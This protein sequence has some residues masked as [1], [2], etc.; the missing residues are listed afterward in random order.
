MTRSAQKGMLQGAC[1][2]AGCLFVVAAPNKSYINDQQNAT[3]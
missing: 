1:V 3:V 2:F